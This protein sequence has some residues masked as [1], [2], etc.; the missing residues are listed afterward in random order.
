MDGTRASSVLVFNHD[1]CCYSFFAPTVAGNRSRFVRPRNGFIGAT[2]PQ[3]LWIFLWPTRHLLSELPRPLRFTLVLVAFSV[4]CLLTAVMFVHEIVHLPSN[5][6][7]A[8][9]VVW[10][11]ICGIPFLVPSSTYYKHRDHHR[12]AAF[13]TKWDG[14]YLPLASMSP[15]WILVYLSQSCRCPAGGRFGI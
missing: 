3:S 15:W 6:F 8:F 14:E 1:Y 10:N 13:G 9:R 5:R 11:L 7:V 2:S 12:Q 4:Q